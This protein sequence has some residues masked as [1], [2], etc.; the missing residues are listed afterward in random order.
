MLILTLFFLYPAFRERSKNNFKPKWK[1]YSVISLQGI[2]IILGSISGFFIAPNNWDSMTY[3]LPRFLHW[4]NNK[5]LDFFVT[6]NQRQNASPI[7]PDLVFAQ[8]FTFFSNDR[9]IFIPIWF[10]I[11]VTSFYIFKITLL[12][13]HK[14]PIAYL[15]S[16]LTLIIPSQ[17]SFISS[18][19]TD[20]IST[21]LVVILV[22]YVT[23]F[24]EKESASIIYLIILMV[25]L[26]LTAKTT[27][28]ILATPVYLYVVINFR[29]FILD[30][31]S[32]Y[33][34]TFVLALLPAFPSVFRVLKFGSK[35][36]SNVFISDFSFQ[37]TLVNI[38]RIFLSNLQ[39][40]I[41]EINRYFEA[42]FMS[43]LNAFELDPNPIGYGSFGD[44]YLTTSLHGDLTGNPLHLALLM[45]ASFALWKK[46]QYRLFILLIPIQ[47]VLVGSIIGWQPWINR[48]TSTILVLGSVLVGIWLGERRKIVR[49]SLVSILL[50]YSSFWIFFN[51]SR[52]LLDSKP[53][54]T[55]A[56]KLGMQSSDLK[57][58]RYD[59]MLPREKQYF[60]VRPELENSYIKAIKQV[61]DS[62][63]EK[64]YI[65]IG[66]DDFE[67]P[68]WALTD[69]KVKIIH[70]QDINLE[71]IK[72]GQTLLFCTVECNMYKLNLEFKDQYVS[73]WR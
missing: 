21:L 23:L 28:L 12:M 45:F 56:D 6:S 51:P 18:T 14:R 10:S 50:F 70:F 53:L 44:F 66:G 35:A 58:I 59:L 25:P 24:R 36:D 60:S 40:P 48:F 57:K 73:L 7:L 20:P 72:Q 8:A 64:L 26:F 22:Y 69:F 67:Y 47:L 17:L 63:T 61:K 65:K 1:Y 31:F 27:A 54:I 16:F 38:F 2:I 13:Q 71:E 3:H 42:M 41:F 11:L 34:L 29:K 4:F 9:F 5:S 30:N 55:V 68:I 37:G 62:G 33:F 52:A 43:F 46:N 15:A 39:T 49:N 19:Q 32:K